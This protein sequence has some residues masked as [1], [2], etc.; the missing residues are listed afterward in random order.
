MGR[1]PLRVSIV[2]MRTHVYGSSIEAVIHQVV[3]RSD[4]IATEELERL[5]GLWARD[6]AADRH[7]A[8]L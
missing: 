5:C 1:M 4:V 7:V 2:P 6:C 8:P 3:F